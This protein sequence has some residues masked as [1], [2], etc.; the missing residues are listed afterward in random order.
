MIRAIVACTIPIVLSATTIGDLFEALKNQPSNKID[1]LTIQKVSLSKNKLNSMLL[2]KLNLFASY[3][4]YNEP[5]N[6][7]P[8]DPIEAGKIIKKNQD[9]PF[10]QDITKVGI[11][12]E[13][14][15]FVKSLDYLKNK[16]DVAKKSAK[17][18]KRVNLYKNEA[19]ILGANAALNYLEN[20][21]NALNTTKKSMLITRKTIEISVD[22]GRMPSIALDKMDKHIND[23]DIA[24]NNVLINEEKV[25]NIIKSLTNIDIRHSVSLKLDK[26]IDK[27]NFILIELLKHKRQMD[28]YDY[29]SSKAKLYMPKIKADALYYKGYGS[30]AVN[31]HKM[32]D[33]DYGYVGISIGV[34]LFDKTTTV[35]MQTK[36]INILKSTKEIERATIELNAQAKLLQKQ[37]Q[38]LQISIKL[39]KDTIEKEKKLLDFAKVAFTEGRMTQ[40]DYL[41]YENELLRA[42]ANYY[43]EIKESWQAVAKLAVIYGNNLEEI[44]K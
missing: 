26:E 27:S 41:G 7:R 15:L 31:T 37:Y 10:S 11:K 39:S 36:K 2:P 13:W 38:M 16:V 9:L 43:K 35:D 1:S 24:I 17:I 20:L 32:V 44:V 3:N 12:V 40:E 19:T 29:K 8:L 42:K 22:S 28:M 5:T 4:S 25:K 6:L 33:T 30:S 18:K 34:S 23:M 14:P 21:L